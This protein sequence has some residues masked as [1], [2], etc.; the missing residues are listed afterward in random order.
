MYFPRWLIS[1]SYSFSASTL[2]P[3]EPRRPVAAS[4]D[5]RAGIAHHVERSGN[6]DQVLVRG[7]FPGLGDGLF[8]AF[9]GRYGPVQPPDRFGEPGDVQR[10]G[11]SGLRHHDMPGKG[12][13]L[14]QDAVKVLVR[15][16]ADNQDELPV[17]RPQF[18]ERRGQGPCRGGNCGRPGRQYGA[19]SVRW[20]YP[21]R[22]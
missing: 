14:L 8:H 21:R 15:Q 22:R 5:R 18:P 11:V 17:G 1:R 10:P 20:C 13:K 9:R 19:H 2:E 4:Q 12:Q 6:N 3:R 7:V 16:N